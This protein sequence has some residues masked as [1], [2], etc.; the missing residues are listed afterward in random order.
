VIPVNQFRTSAEEKKLLAAV[1]RLSEAQRDTL[2][3]FA[4][5]LAR[6]EDGPPAEAVEQTPL[7]I[8]RPAEESVIKAIRRLTATYPML[9]KDRMLHQT[10]GLMTQHIV[11]G[12]AAEE[13]IDELEDMF[14]A[15]YN[16]MKNDES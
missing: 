5:F 16:D 6:R 1:R 14:R 4:E 15:H 3:A 11:Q 2:L 10:A 7:D 13:I 8:P 12:R 9:E